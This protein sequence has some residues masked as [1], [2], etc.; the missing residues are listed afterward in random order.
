[1]KFISSLVSIFR[2]K[3]QV[4]TPLPKVE[5]HIS[6]FDNLWNQLSLEL[7]QPKLRLGATVDEEKVRSLRAQLA[8]LE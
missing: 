8:A 4:A 2:R 3:R 7:A 5:V 1:M 6:D